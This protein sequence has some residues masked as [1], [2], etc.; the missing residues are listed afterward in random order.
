MQENLDH[1]Q[2][3]FLE[4]CISKGLKA[5]G[6]LFLM[7]KGDTCCDIG[8]KLHCTV[9][10]GAVSKSCSLVRCNSALSAA[11]SPILCQPL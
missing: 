6:S 9:R 5:K 2:M 4:I 10:L 1:I 8:T 7:A 11:E 3:S